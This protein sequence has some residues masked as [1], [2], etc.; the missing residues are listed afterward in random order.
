MSAVITSS[1]D[2]EDILEALSLYYFPDGSTE[3]TE[4]HVKL[5]KKDKDG[6]EIS[7]LISPSKFVI[8]FT[9]RQTPSRVEPLSPEEALEKLNSITGPAEENESDTDKEG[10]DE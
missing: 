8:Q 4:M 3:F 7:K 9:G 10:S 6:N 2:P 5:I 1:P